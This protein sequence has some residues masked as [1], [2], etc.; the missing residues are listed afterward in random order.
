MIS[1]TLTQEEKQALLHTFAHAWCDELKKTLEAIKPSDLWK[2]LEGKSVFRL[3][4]EAFE[5][6]SGVTHKV[7]SVDDG[8]V[9]DGEGVP[10][11]VKGQPVLMS[12]TQFPEFFPRANAESVLNA[13]NR[14][15]HALK[16]TPQKIAKEVI[17]ARSPKP[18]P[19]PILTKD[20]AKKA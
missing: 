9:H 1:T 2:Y 5:D 16:T 12:I 20:I 18:G 8:L 4:R 10:A 19:E 6:H 15:A 13:M 17:E 14:I 11:A 7:Y 3:E